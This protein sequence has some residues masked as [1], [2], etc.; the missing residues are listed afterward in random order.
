MRNYNRVGRNDERGIGD[1]GEC[2]GYGGCV[3]IETFL[4]GSL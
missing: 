1:G 2:G 4:C 3:D